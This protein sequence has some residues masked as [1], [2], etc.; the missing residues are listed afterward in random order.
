MF[1]GGLFYGLAYACSTAMLPFI[2]REVFG[3][4]DF[5][6]IYSW[7][8]LVFNGIG[9]LGATGWALV[10]EGFGWGGFFVGGLGV[11]TVTFALLAYTWIAGD[12]ARRRTWFKPD[13]LIASE[14]ASAVVGS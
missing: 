14:S 4:R 10:A 3:G 12:R 6:K 5:D 9:A 7:M 1:A 11:L 2:V 13:E 8:V